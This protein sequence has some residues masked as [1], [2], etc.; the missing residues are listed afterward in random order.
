[1]KKETKSSKLNISPLADRVLIKPEETV[2]KTASGIIIPDAAKQD[3]AT[4][5]S[6]VAVGPGKLNDTGDIIPMSVKVGQKVYFNP[7]WESEVEIE[8]EKYYLVHEGD[9]KAIIK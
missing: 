9:V 6:I 8:D 1:M 3:K 4:R 2:K 5:G 7:G